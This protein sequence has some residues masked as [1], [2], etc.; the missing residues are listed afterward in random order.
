MAVRKSSRVRMYGRED[1][2]YGLREALEGGGRVEQQNGDQLA[3]EHREL[4]PWN[5]NS[6]V[7]PSPG[8]V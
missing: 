7:P 5:A 2:V 8:A 1:L 4:F 3:E 6:H